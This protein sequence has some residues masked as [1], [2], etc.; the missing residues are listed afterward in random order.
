MW[1]NVLEALEWRHTIV[2]FTLGYKL[3]RGLT[4]DAKHLL[5][6]TYKNMISENLAK[7]IVQND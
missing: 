7:S 4:S 6:N 1:Q 3:H 2:I 5:H